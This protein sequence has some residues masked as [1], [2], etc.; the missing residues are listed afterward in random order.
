MGIAAE[1]LDVGCALFAAAVPDIGDGDEL[2]VHVLGVLQKGGNQGLLHAVAA[3][4]DADADAVVGAEDLGVAAC[5]SKNSLRDG[6]CGQGLALPRGIFHEN[7]GNIREICE[8]SCS[9]GGVRKG[10]LADVSVGSSAAHPL[11]DIDLG[12]GW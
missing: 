10:V 8:S 5:A 3:A 9:E 7:F 11:G 4:D 6:G 1:L 12:Q 2:E